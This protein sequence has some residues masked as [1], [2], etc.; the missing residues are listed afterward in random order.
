MNEINNPKMVGLRPWFCLINYTLE[1]LPNY[2]VDLFP[3]IYIYN[4]KN[5]ELYSHQAQ[6]LKTIAMIF[7]YITI[8]MAMVPPNLHP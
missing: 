8:A 5:P 7:P 4:P 6:P 1:H 2:L 3:Y